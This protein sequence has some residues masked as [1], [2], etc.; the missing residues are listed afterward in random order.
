MTNKEKIIAAF[1]VS[2]GVFSAVQAAQYVSTLSAKEKS[3]LAVVAQDSANK[4][5]LCDG[6]VEFSTRTD[7][8]KRI[9]ATA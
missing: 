1:L 9:K 8:P 6:V 3:S 5:L 2:V 7:D 4:I